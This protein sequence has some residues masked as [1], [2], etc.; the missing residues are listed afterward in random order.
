[1]VIP[2][3][4]ELEVLDLERYIGVIEDPAVGARSVAEDE[5][6][7]IWQAEKDTLDVGPK[8]LWE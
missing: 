4:A 1:V 7:Q 5:R 8:V 3:C 2:C 6:A